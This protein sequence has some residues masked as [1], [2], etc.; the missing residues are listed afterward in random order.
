MHWGC[1]RTGADCTAWSAGGLGSREAAMDA[2][3]GSQ[4]L[5]WQHREEVLARHPIRFCYRSC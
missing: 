2:L 5:Y 3:L 1:I 4:P